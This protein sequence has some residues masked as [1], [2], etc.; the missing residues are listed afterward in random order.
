MELFKDGLPQWL[1]KCML[2]MREHQPDTLKGWIQSVQ[3]E[4]AREVELCT[5][6]GSC[7]GSG[8]E[9]T[10]LARQGGQPTKKRDP[11]AMDVDINLVRTSPLSQ[12]ER[13]RLLKERKCFNCKKEGHQARNCPSKRKSSQGERKG[14]KS[15]SKAHTAQIEEIDDKEE[16]EELKEP[17]EEAPPAYENLVC[18]VHTLKNKEREALL[19][20]LALQ[21]FA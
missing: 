18:Q 7:R 2:L 13:L 5:T 19:D 3:E 21:D 14:K 11:N 10:R 8:R 20:D 12:E 6:L 17:A 1:T 16:E 9:A 4:I 15:S